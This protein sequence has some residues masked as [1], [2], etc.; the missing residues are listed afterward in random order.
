MIGSDYKV[1]IAVEGQILRVR[2]AGRYKLIHSMSLIRSVREQAD[3][4]G[5]TQVLLDTT[6]IPQPI[7]DMERYTLAVEAVDAWRGLKVAGIDLTESPDRFLEN[8]AVNRG[9]RFR[10]F[11]SET[12]ALE[13]LRDPRS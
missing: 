7:P 9:A 1:E 5:V 8:V 12:Q 11:N 13:W 6:A 4:H 10:V 2:A 3:R